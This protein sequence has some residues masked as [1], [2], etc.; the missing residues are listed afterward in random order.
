MNQG[1]A[2]TYP[3][4]PGQT[5]L[6]AD[7]VT[8]IQG[9]TRVN[10]QNV[11]VGPATA[12]GTESIVVTNQLTAP[13][14]DIVTGDVVST[15]TL[16]GGSSEVDARVDFGSTPVLAD[17]NRTDLDTLAIGFSQTD[18]TVTGTATSTVSANQAPPVQ[19]TI[20]TARSQDRCFL[21]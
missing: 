12:P 6:Y 16:T 20:R 7:T 17:F 4:S 19:R 10:T 18:P 1:Q 5:F 2:V 11:T 9:S 3:S 15:A 8:T 13:G 21:R 14:G